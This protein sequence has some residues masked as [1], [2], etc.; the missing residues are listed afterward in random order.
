MWTQ[1][2]DAADEVAHEKPG[3]MG[4]CI[5]HSGRRFVYANASGCTCEEINSGFTAQ[6]GVRASKQ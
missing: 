5:R 3:D 4:C 2:A 1:N 6:P